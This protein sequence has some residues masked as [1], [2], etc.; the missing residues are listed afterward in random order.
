VLRLGLQVSNEPG[1]AS[2]VAAPAPYGG[3][4]NGSPALEHYFLFHGNLTMYDVDSS[5]IP[6]LAQKVPTLADG[7]WKLTPNGGMEVTWK[8]KP[9]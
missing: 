3:S 8:I 6:Q 2:G 9:R 7:D 1:R 4:G 5:I